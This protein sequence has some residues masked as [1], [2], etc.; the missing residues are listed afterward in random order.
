MHHAVPVCS[1][2]AWNVHHLPTIKSLRSHLRAPHEPG[3]SPDAV[4]PLSPTSAPS[5]AARQ[6][7][8]NS[9]ARGVFE[10]SAGL[11]ASRESLQVMGLC[12]WQDHQTATLC[13]SHTACVLLDRPCVAVIASGGVYFLFTSSSRSTV[14]ARCVPPLRVRFQ[15]PPTRTPCASPTN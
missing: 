12:V 11:E 13:S 1:C 3:S 9:G 8:V 15:R 14:Y 4:T 10:T 2:L 5:C 7:H 6:M